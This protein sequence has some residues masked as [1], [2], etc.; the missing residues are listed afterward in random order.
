MGGGWVDGEDKINFI[1]SRV[2]STITLAETAIIRLNGK[3]IATLH[4][5][6]MRMIVVYQYPIHFSD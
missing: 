1:Y 4:V 2:Q 3:N 5:Y 6:D